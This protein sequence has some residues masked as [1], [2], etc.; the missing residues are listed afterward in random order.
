M[1]FRLSLLSWLGIATVLVASHS[2][3]AQELSGHGSIAARVPTPSFD[4][5]R[6]KS[7]VEKTI[8]SDATL[9]ALDKRL[10]LAYA[11][12]RREFPRSRGA[13][14]KAQRDWLKS[15]EACTDEHE[16]IESQVWCLSGLYE[17]QSS[18][19]LKMLLPALKLKAPVSDIDADKAIAV[20]RLM[21]PDDLQR[22]TDSENRDAL[23]E[24]SCRFFQRFPKEAA[25]L[26]G[27]YFYSSRDAWA[28]ICRTIDIATQV[29]E[30]EAFIT[31]LEK[32][33]GETE[34]E[35]TMI[36]GVHRAQHLAHIMAVVDSAPDIDAYRREHGKSIAIDFLQHWAQQGLWEK[37][38]Y[39]ELQQALALAHPA[40]Q[41]YYQQR[42]HLDET[43]AARVANYH[44]EVLIEEY[45][46]RTGGPNMLNSYS[47]CFTTADL[48]DYLKNGEVPLKTCIYDEYADT[49]KQAS[50]RRLLGLAIVNGYP[51]SLIKRLITDGAQLDSPPEKESGEGGESLLMLAATRAD[52]I[53][54]LLIAGADPNR[55]N[56][57][58]KTALMY[59]VQERNINGVRRLIKAGVNVNAITSTDV[60]CTGLKAGNRSAL[61]Y[62]AWYGTPKIMRA[63]L[64]A[65]AKADHLD[66]N[67]KSALDYLGH[68]TLLSSEQREAMR[69]MLRPASH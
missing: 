24:V 25:V 35:G 54:A 32:I 49:S 14:I 19:F 53:N 8:C 37:R 66:T 39:A 65:H 40:L 2:T 44:I 33:E 50:L 56:N 15:R 41:K 43:H 21:T 7:F 69:A 67:G 11:E 45:A 27:A 57:F 46:G 22:A 61:M 18:L 64:D 47:G 26:F 6:A 30:T 60:S 23:D 38:R 17:Q 16:N 59:A 42:F 13:L 5:A 3:C 29:P 51:L 62:A 55:M 48:D 31:A 63:L 12:V 1:I 4:C 9:A 52:V 58:G 28:P 20:L 68:N 34:C 10:A 36:Y